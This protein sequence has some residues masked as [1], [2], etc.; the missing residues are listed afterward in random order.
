MGTCF[1]NPVT[2]AKVKKV[3]SS[4]ETS[5]L[6]PL[7]DFSVLTEISLSLSFACPVTNDVMTVQSNPVVMNGIPWLFLHFFLN[8]LITERLPKSNGELCG[9][10]Y[11]FKLTFLEPFSPAAS[12]I[13]QSGSVMSSLTTEEENGEP[14]GNLDWSNE[15]FE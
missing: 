2:I 7:I 1:D 5:I 8:P 14:L 13:E 9:Q 11:S 15:S 3:T 4:L 12:L 10:A 6:I